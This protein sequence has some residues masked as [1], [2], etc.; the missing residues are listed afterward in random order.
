M[1][2]GPRQ[3]GKACT[4]AHACPESRSRAMDQEDEIHSVAAPK[5]MM[6]A[7]EMTVTE[8]GTA[9][10]ESQAWPLCASHEIIPHHVC[11]VLNEVNRAPKSAL[12]K[13]SGV[14]GA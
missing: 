9:E 7:R 3:G 12:S 1:L 4:A 10:R 6:L 14:A 11:S 8:L 5:Q 2:R 13:P